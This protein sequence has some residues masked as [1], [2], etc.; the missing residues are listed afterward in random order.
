[1]HFSLFVVGRWY[2]ITKANTSHW[3]LNVLLLGKSFYLVSCYFHWLIYFVPKYIIISLNPFQLIFRVSI[4]CLLVCLKSY[5]ISL[6]IQSS[7]PITNS[8][9]PSNMY[10][11]ENPK[12]YTSL[13]WNCHQSSLQ[14][15]SA[16]QNNRKR[17]GWKKWKDEFLQ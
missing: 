15:F 6:L 13:N 10:S 1:M 14:G 12:I 17:C 11:C 7:W 5:Q 16:Q 8:I 2:P 3:R 9:N 4:T